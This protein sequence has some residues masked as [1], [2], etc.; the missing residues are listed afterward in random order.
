MFHVGHG[1]VGGDPL[2]DFQ[3]AAGNVVAH[4]VHG[5]IPGIEGHCRATVHADA[6]AGWHPN[7]HSLECGGVLQGEHGVLQGAGI[8]EGRAGEVGGEN[9]GEKIADSGSGFH[10]LASNQVEKGKWQKGKSDRPPVLES[11]YATTGRMTLPVLTGRVY[12][13]VYFP[14]CH[15]PFLQKHQFT[16]IKPLGLGH[17]VKGHQ[18]TGR[19]GY[20]LAVAASGSTR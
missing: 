10:A 3:G 15:V 5:P 6:R 12:G 20:R 18:Q 4:Q 17:G 8:G 2:A 1:V 9:R 13:R 11:H 19:A 7:A 14:F 16:L